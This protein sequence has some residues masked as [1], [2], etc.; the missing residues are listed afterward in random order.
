MLETSPTGIAAARA[1]DLLP[2]WGDNAI[3]RSLLDFIARVTTPDEPDYVSPADRIAVFDNDGTLW[4]EQPMYTQ[5]AF[6]LD[7]V[8]EVVDQHPELEEDPAFQAVLDRDRA[9]LAALG[10][11]AIARLIG[12]THG[13]TTTEEFAGIVDRWIT[14]ARHPITKRLYTEMIYQPMLELMQLLRA[15]NFEVYIVTGGGVEF[16]RQWSQ[17]VYGVPPQRVVGS[18]AKVEYVVREGTPMLYRHTQVEMVDDRAGKPVGI[19]QV[20]GRRPI[21]AFGNSDG[22]FEMLEWTTATPG[23]HLGLLVHH[24]DGDREWAYDRDS[25]VGQLRR[26]LDEAHDRGWLVVDMKDDWRAIYPGQS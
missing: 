6:A 11:P 12:A 25:H 8:R 17:R 14:T 13:H 7:R 10:E 15:C 1:T 26:G 9:T 5:L 2:S 24:T 4:T 16:V 21:A 23:P 3:K 22:D 19:H 20:I 18:R